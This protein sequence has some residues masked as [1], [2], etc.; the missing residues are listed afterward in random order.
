MDDLKQV[1][2]LGYRIKRLQARNKTLL[3]RQKNLTKLD[4]NFT[5]E[6][7]GEDVSESVKEELDAI[8]YDLFDKN[9]CYEY[10]PLITTTKKIGHLQD[11]FIGSLLRFTECLI[12]NADDSHELGC[13]LKDGVPG[14]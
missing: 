4:R 13:Q 12:Y 9:S 3:S 10:L 8:V 7:T 11:R 1:F 6:K 14:K 2:Q 5:T